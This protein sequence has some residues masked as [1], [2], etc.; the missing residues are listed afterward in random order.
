MSCKLML[1]TSIVW[2]MALDSTS[3]GPAIRRFLGKLGETCKI[4]YTPVIV[5][6]V[7]MAASRSE[8]RRLVSILN[9]IADPMGPS[10]AKLRGEALKRTRAVE[11]LGVYDVMITL[12]AVDSGAVLATG[13]WRQA[14]YFMS[15]SKAK[16]LYIPVKNLL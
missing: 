1:D 2:V 7:E 11:R 6:E 16:P 5:E 14:S 8:H 15:L 12:A 3:L 9:S 10:R 13:D 4:G